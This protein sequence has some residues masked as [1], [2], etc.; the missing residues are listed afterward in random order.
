MTDTREENVEV[1]GADEGGKPDDS[2]D[3]PGYSFS[4][5]FRWSMVQGSGL[6]SSKI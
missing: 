1:P 5:L 6:K 2:V 4:Y 3:G